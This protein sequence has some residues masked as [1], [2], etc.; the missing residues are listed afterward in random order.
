[1][2]I[3][4]VNAPNMEATHWVEIKC[5]KNMVYKKNLQLFTMQFHKSHPNNM[6][7]VFMLVAISTSMFKILTKPFQQVSNL[8]YIIP[9][10]MTPT[11]TLIFIGLQYNE[12]NPNVDFMVQ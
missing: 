11:Q 8:K 7:Q 9:T 5:Q 10:S 6:E 4:L 2:K 12:P 1:M 3:E